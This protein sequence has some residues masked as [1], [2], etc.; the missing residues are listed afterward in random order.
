VVARGKGQPEAAGGSQQ[1]A[2]KTD[3]PTGGCGRTG[4]DRHRL[5][6]PHRLV[7][8]PLPLAGVA[9]AQR[10]QAVGFQPDPGAAMGGGGTGD[11]GWGRA[12][13][14]NEETVERAA[15]WRQG[16]TSACRIDTLAWNGEATQKHWQQARQTG[17]QVGSNGNSA[18]GHAPRL[19]KVQHQRQPPAAL[20]GA[21]G[22]HKVG[23]GQVHAVR[24]T[25]VRGTAGK[26]G[27]IW[28]R[29]C[30][31][32][33][34]RQR[35]RRGSSGRVPLAGCLSAP[36]PLRP[37]RSQAAGAGARSEEDASHI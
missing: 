15:S 8:R 22:G 23:Q 11:G 13:A 37:T 16:P 5:H 14:C 28:N 10:A 33:R 2:L 6:G 31:G 7:Q 3:A 27:G 1:K 19:L 29:G 17:P 4:G 36:P 9:Q 21:D 12:P 26:G 18:A 30:E 20:L 24:C 25:A 32:G 35:Q 34:Q